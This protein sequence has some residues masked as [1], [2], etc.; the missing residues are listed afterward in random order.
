[1]FSFK[2]FIFF[3]NFKKI[4]TDFSKLPEHEEAQCCIV[5]LM[6][7][8][9]EGFLTTKEGDKVL[10]DDIFALFNNI[11]CPNLAGKPKLFFIQSCRDGNLK[12]IILNFFKLNLFFFIC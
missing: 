8:G 11:N 12:F 1:L 5:C 7:H 2:L 3:K 4:I 6:S 10:I 9:E